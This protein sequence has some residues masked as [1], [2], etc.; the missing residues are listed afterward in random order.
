VAALDQDFW[1]VLIQVIVK[2]ADW[3]LVVVQESPREF[4][5]EFLLGLRD[6][7]VLV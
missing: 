6:R 3:A 4:V 1:R 2:V 7:Q 5:R